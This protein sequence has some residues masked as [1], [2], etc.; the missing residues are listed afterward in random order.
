[1]SNITQIAPRPEAVDDFE[2]FWHQCVKKLDKALA[3]AKWDAIT[4]ERGLETKMLDRD[5]G[6]YVAV[7]LKATPQELI[8]AMKRYA[9]SQIDSNFKIKDGG[10][11]TCG[12][13]VWLNRGRWQDE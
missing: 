2:A 1:M 7:H 11:F 4:S 9:R 13:A 6:S 10:K 5:S 12:P 3:K 8:E